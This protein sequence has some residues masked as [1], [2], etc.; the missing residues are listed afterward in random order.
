MDAAMQT[1]LQEVEKRLSELEQERHSLLRESCGESVEDY[2]LR[3]PDGSP[4]QLS[5]LFG[6]KSELVVIHNMGHSCP[7][8]T[9]WAEGFKST[10]PYIQQRSAFVLVS[11]DSPD[12]LR[13]FAAERG[14]NFPVASAAGTG[15]FADMG[16]ADEKGNAGPGISS[17]QKNA[18]GRITRISRDDFGPG[19][20]YSN[21]FA[22]FDLLPKPEGQFYEWFMP[23]HDAALKAG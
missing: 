8:C 17:L 16:F 6:D 14:W 22:I 11:P 12:K 10:F 7:Y 15:I 21:V 2:T 1:K 13:E 18:D 9:L 20:R 3:R 4:V 19:D 23:D 5:E